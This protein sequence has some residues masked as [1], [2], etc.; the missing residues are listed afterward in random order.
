MLSG[1]IGQLSRHATRFLAG[2]VCLGLLLP[3]LAR[4]LGPLLGASVWL[5][6]AL[7][8][9]RLDWQRARVVLS[10]PLPVLL[11]LLWMLL[12]TPLLAWLLLRDSGLS[13][14]LVTA[15]VL[16]AG[17]APLMSSPSL[18]MILGLD[19]ALALVVMIPATLLVPF[20]VPLIALQLLGLDLGLDPLSWSLQLS[21]FVASALLLA[22]GLRRWLGP[23]RIERQALRLDAAMVVL[24]LLF[25][26]AVMDGVTARLLAEPAQV[27]TMLLLAFAA[28]ATLLL[29]GTL[30]LRAL[31]AA[32]GNCIGFINANRNVGVILAVLPAGA[33]ADIPLFFAL[34][35]MPMYIMPALL[36]K[37]YRGRGAI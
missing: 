8:M 13:A 7:A 18:A 9:I 24:L 29:I 19:G 15:M 22:L 6:L 31:G 26:V 5:L 3:D 25:A 14:G 17:G 20:S 16:M 4:L 35:Q 27:L 32:V 36:R 10:R 30:A 33:D 28:Y 12:I 23:G 11:A 1:W 2:G 34:W 37:L 21:A